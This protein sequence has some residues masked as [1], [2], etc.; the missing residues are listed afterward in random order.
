MLQEQVGRELCCGR[1]GEKITGVTQGQR[2]SLCHYV[3]LYFECY[4]DIAKVYEGLW[5]RF[6]WWKCESR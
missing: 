4:Y 6:V 1:G 5:Q 3:I 2:M